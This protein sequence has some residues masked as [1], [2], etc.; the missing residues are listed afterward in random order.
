MTYELEL[1]TDGSEKV[2]HIGPFT[3]V[4]KTT[5]EGNRCV[6]DFTAQMEGGNVT[7][8]WVREIAEG[9]KEMTWRVNTKASDGRTLDQTMVFRRK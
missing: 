6:T 9:G 1:P 4:S 7:G 2:N 3:H 8:Q 5:V